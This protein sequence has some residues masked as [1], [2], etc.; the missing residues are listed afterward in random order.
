MH[1]VDTFILKLQNIN[2][3][4]FAICILYG[5]LNAYKSLDTTIP[6]TESNK[7]VYKSLY[8]CQK[9]DKHLRLQGSCLLWDLR[10]MTIFTFLM[11]CIMCYVGV[12]W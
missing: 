12:E 3:D 9:G 8:E 11:M 6:T 5:T 10:T 2:Q 7:N 1:C 4:D